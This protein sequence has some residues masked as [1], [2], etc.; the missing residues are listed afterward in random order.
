MGTIAMDCPAHGIQPVTGVIGGNAIIEFKGVQITCPLCGAAGPILAGSYELR[1]ERKLTT[2]YRPTP[3]SRRRLQM[4]LR[5]AQIELAKPGATEE[6]IAAR[7]EAQLEREAP[8]VA[9]TFRGWVSK[10]AGNFI[11]IAG[12]LIALLSLYVTSQGITAQQME[13]ILDRHI[14]RPS[15]MEPPPTSPVTPE[16]SAPP[17]VY[18]TRNPV[19]EA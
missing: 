14:E 15:Q 19:Q 9:K 16:P 1:D 10:N 18:E 6:R 12:L 7:L 13:E 2:L 11:G 5:W 8:E 17:R 3:A 4:A